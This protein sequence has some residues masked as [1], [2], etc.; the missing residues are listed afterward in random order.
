MGGVPGRGVKGIGGAVA[1]HDAETANQQELKDE[2]GA[3]QRLINGVA[4]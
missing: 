2:G 1:F 4:S 3:I